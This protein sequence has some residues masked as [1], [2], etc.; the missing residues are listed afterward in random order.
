VLVLVSMLNITNKCR[1]RFSARLEYIFSQIQTVLPVLHY[2]DTLDLSVYPQ[3]QENH[4]LC[5]SHT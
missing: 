5:A 4:L 1:V 3:H 2:P